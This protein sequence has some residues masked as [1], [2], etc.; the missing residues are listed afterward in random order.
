MARVTAGYVHPDARHNFRR[1]V[2]ELQ[3][4]MVL[5]RLIVFRAI[6]GTTARIYFLREIVL[7]FLNAKKQLE[8]LG[9]EVDE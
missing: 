4:P 5:Q 7:A 1:T 6:T 8:D 2:H 3:Q 9:Y